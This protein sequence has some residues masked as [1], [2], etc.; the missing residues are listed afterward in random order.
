M[1]PRFHL[2]V[3][4]FV[5]GFA[6]AAPVGPIGVLVIRRSLAGG[7]RSGLASGLGA[8]VA[9]AIFALA[10]ALGLASLGSGLGSRAWTLRVI[11]GAILCAIGIRAMIAQRRA[12][13]A[14][15]PDVGHGRAF[16][17]TLALT[18]ASPISILSFAA[19]AASLGVAPGA[20]GDAFSLV[21]GVFAGSAAWWAIL[22]SA[23]GALR[24]RVPERAFAWL[25]RASGLALIAFGA[26]TI[27]S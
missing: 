9:D 3:R 4:G 25:D 16:A 7:A 18:L 1:D 13:R 10:G 2:V 22:A 17:G 27:A 5:I 26:A 8:A 11:G 20:W 24:R 6:L 12:A 14:R 15:A 23:V 21:L 19:V